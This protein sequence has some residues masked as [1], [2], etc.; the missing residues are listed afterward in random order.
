MFDVICVTPL[1]ATTQDNCLIQAIEFI[2]YHQRNIRRHIDLA[3]TDQEVSLPDMSW[4]SERWQ[5]AIFVKKIKQDRPE[6]AHRHHLELCVFFYLMLGHKSGDICISGSDQFS[7]YRTQLVDWAEYREQIGQYGLQVE[8]PVDGGSFVDH[9]REWLRSVAQKT[10]ASFPEN[11]YIRI[12]REQPII[13]RVKKENRS[14]GIEQFEATISQR[15]EP[16]TIMDSLHSTQQWLAWD[17]CFGLLS[18]FD[19]KID[20][21][22]KHYIATT[23][24]YGCNLGPIQAAGS[25][26]DISRYQIAWVNQRHVTEEKLNQAI[27]KTINAYDLFDLP[28][29]WGSGKSASVDGKL[30]DVYEEYLLS[31]YH[32]RYGGYGGI[33]YYHVSDKYI[34]LFSHFIPYLIKVV[35]NCI[36]DCEIYNLF[37][38]QSI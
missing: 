17:K 23:F 35:L 6:T 4:I 18:G 5:V 36:V 7:D 9:T 21:P 14:Q 33:G 38:I 8:L 27:V 10:D 28:K 37:S 26:K 3:E 1:V 11:E 16:V 25:I 32:I 24:C 13:T 29:I 31:E 20:D 34:A 15:L 30:W 12:E 22:A 2:K 19:S